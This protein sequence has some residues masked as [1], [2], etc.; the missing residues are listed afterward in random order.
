MAL[1]HAKAWN[2][3]PARGTAAQAPPHL[4]L[5]P[6]ENPEDL[7]RRI[8]LES[9]GRAALRA[10][11]EADPQGGAPAEDYA[12]HAGAAMV[13]GDAGDDEDVVARYREGEPWI[14]RPAR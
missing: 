4:V 8:R 11:F 10:H 12:P 3:E 9:I 1:G 13:E 14:E 6:S 5:T 7:F 2:D